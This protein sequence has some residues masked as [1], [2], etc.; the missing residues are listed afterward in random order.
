M[1][2]YTKEGDPILTDINF[3]GEQLEVTRDNTRDEYGSNEI[4]TF[5]CESIIVEEKT[6]L[7]TGCEGYEI[8]YFLAESF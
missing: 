4:K 3:N 7:I 6:Y 1:V 5:N 8:P 2:G